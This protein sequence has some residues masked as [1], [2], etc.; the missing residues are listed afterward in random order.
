M[1]AM[2]AKAARVRG[3]APDPLEDEGVVDVGRGRGAGHRHPV[4]VGGDV[5][6]AAPLA[7][8]RGVWAGEVTA[9]L[10]P[11]R[12]GVEDQ[13]GVAAQHAD[14]RGVHLRQ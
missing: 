14:Q 3:T 5:V 8:V 1:R 9:A 13:V 4:P 6:L 10:G 11:H 12:A 7:P 2:T